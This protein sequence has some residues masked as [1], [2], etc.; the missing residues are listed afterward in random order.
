MVKKE[1]KEL[2]NLIK[3]YGK[4]FVDYLK[5]TYLAFPSSKIAMAYPEYLVEHKQIMENFEKEMEEK[6]F[7]EVL[8]EYLKKLEELENKYKGMLLKL[9]RG[10]LLKKIK[11]II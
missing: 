3:S 1:D 11:E 6:P 7:R 10:Q 2:Q 5:F 8:S 4:D 9:K